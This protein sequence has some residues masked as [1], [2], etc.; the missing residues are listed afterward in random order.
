MSVYMCMVIGDDRF[1]VPTWV[2]AAF[3]LLAGNAGMA[4]VIYTVVTWY[5][6][7]FDFSSHPKRLL[8]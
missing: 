8:R 2:I 5:D 3:I 7:F 4:A 6:T 1:K